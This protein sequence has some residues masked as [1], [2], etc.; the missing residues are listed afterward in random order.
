MQSIL[1]VRHAETTLNATRTVQYPD[2]PLS[3]RGHWQAKQLANRL[4]VEGVAQVASSDYARAED[5]ARAICEATKASLTIEPMLRERH[6]GT[7]RGQ[8]YQ[9]VGG[10]V[11]SETVDP[12][13]GE[14]WVDFVERIDRLWAWVLD[15]AQQTPGVLVVV[16]HGLVCRALALRHLTLPPGDAPP[17]FPNASVTVIEPRR[18]WRV[19]M[20]ASD[21]GHAVAEE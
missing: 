9:E 18:P 16:T 11:F 10:L 21:D 13:A 8:P 6:L 7:L 20:L 4:R 15:R 19:T 12:E 2:T 5:T 3:T 17:R 14:R 1:L